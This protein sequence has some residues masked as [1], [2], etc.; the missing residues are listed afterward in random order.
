MYLDGINT[1]KDP[2]LFAD[3]IRDEVRA[4]KLGRDRNPSFVASVVGSM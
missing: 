4:R 3:K 1:L 2:K